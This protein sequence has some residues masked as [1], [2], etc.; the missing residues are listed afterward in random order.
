MRLVIDASA[1]LY[2]AA[3]RNGFS[4]LGPHSTVAPPLLWSEF[5]SALHQLVRRQGI[6]AD[7]AAHARTA[8]RDAQIERSTPPDLLE[9]AWRVADEC[10][11]AK[12]YDAE[13]VAFARL[14][15]APLWTRDARLARGAARI[16][17][18]L[19]PADLSAGRW[20]KADAPRARKA[21]PGSRRCCPCSLLTRF[22]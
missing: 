7:L 1:A 8:L 12:T 11:W 20:I 22:R 21:R 19:T 6:S 10:G 2:F 15:D 14:V 13:Y 4:Q 16:V 17:S 18:V 5:V 9:E 3:S